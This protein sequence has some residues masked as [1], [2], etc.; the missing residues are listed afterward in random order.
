LPGP[1]PISAVTSL[2]KPRKDRGSP[3][4][5]PRSIQKLRSA[6]IDSVFRIAKID[7]EVMQRLG[8]DC[9]PIVCKSP[10]HWTPPPSAPGEF[11]DLFG[12]TWR[13]QSYGEGY[14]M[15]LRKNPLATAHIE[16]LDDY[17]WPDP[18]DPGYTDGHAEE[19]ET[20]YERT[21]YALMADS[22]LKSIWETGYFLRG[23]RR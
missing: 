3:V 6:T 4:L 10:L 21:D 12:V 16:D 20:I 11:I 13:Q 17:P 15:E 14:Y 22:G 18:L 2:H 19:V 23:Y 7:E 1:G 9:Y 5:R 8:S